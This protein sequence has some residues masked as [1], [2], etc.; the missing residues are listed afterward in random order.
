MAD[1]LNFSQRQDQAKQRKDLRYASD[2]EAI[3][4]PKTGARF[5]MLPGGRWVEETV[6]RREMGGRGAQLAEAPSRPHGRE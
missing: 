5:R 4:H 1:G 6:W 2:G 3:I